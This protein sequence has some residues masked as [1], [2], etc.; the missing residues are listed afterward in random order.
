MSTND[1]YENFAGVNATIESLQMLLPTVATESYCDA[2]KRISTYEIDS[3]EIEKIIGNQMA[4]MKST[5]FPVSEQSL[6]KDAMKIQCESLATIRGTYL[7]PE[8]EKLQDSLVKC[9]IS[10]YSDFVKAIN[11]THIEAANVALLKMSKAFGAYRSWY[12]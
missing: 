9:Q 4:T 6:V 1:F 10:G 5:L 3:K 2:L 11:T 8:I 7:T 12:L